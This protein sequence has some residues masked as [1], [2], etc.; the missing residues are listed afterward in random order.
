[1]PF[2]FIALEHILLTVVSYLPAL[3]VYSHISRSLDNHLLFSVFCRSVVTWKIAST[4]TSRASN[5]FS[6]PLVKTR[7]AN[8]LR[9]RSMLSSQKAAVRR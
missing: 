9:L 2:E 1:M 8:P 7:T 3:M 5:L 6:P 4:S